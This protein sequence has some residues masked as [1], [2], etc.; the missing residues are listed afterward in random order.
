MARLYAVSSPSFALS[1][2][3]CHI[4]AAKDLSLTENARAFALIMM[5]IND[6][7]IASFYNKYHYTFWRPET[8]ISRGSGGW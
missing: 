8:S 6:S 1:M 2:V 3:A 5:G 7:L 4:A